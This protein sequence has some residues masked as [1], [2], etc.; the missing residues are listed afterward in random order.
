[1]RIVNR[2]S[3]ADPLSYELLQEMAY[4][5]GRAG[6]RAEAALK[7]LQAHDDQPSSRGG[8]DELVGR[9]GE[10]VWCFVV[11]REACGFRDAEAVLA[12]LAVPAEVRGRMGPYR[13]SR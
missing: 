5:L 1:M 8:R 12:Q 7:A 3:A 13:N 11:Q 4:S 10:A 2:A 9:A 6:R